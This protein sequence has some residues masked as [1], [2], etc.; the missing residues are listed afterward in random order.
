MFGSETGQKVL[1]EEAERSI[2]EQEAQGQ[3]ISPEQRALSI[4]FARYLGVVSAVATVIF[5]PLGIAIFA[6]IFM[7][8]LNAVYGN[9]A[10]FRH[11]YAVM[12]HSSL[13]TSLLTLV[14][15]PL[16]LAKEEIGASPARLSVFVPMLPEDS[17]V[18]HLFGA[19]DLVWIWSLLNMSIGLA[20]LYKRKTGPLAT[21]LF[22]IYA[23]I[24]L[25]IAVVLTVF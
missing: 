9:E 10:S 22:G 11:V 8:L 14:L 12:T 2:R 15:V 20:V 5:T 24:A 6:A 4:Q 17:F 13:L 23:A 18:T 3:E 19:I 7:A 25:T 21:T 16:M 1:R